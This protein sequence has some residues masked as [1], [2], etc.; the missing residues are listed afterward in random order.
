MKRKMAAIIGVFQ[1]RADRYVLGGYTEQKSIETLLDEA[2]K[3][4]GLEGIEL[5]ARYMDF[6]NPWE[7][8]NG[9][10]DRGLEIPLL[11]PDTFAS[12]EYGRGS[13]IAPERNTRQ[14]AIDHIRQSMDLA[15]EIGCNMVSPWFGNDGY[16]YVMQI[17]YV[18]SWALMVEGIRACAEH[19]PKVRIAIEYKIKEPRT[20]SFLN[21][22]A[23]TLL[24]IDEV[25]LPNV[26]INLDVGHALQGYE[27]MA[28]C[29]ALIDAKGKRLFH[30]H[31]NDNYRY[32]DDDMMPCSVHT[33]EW[34][35]LFFWLDRI[36]YG[37]W[38]SLDVHAFR[39]ADKIGVARESLAWVRG[40]EAAARRI[41]PSRAERIFAAQ[42]AVASTAML[43]EALLPS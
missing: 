22:M 4:E 1:G 34:M 38:L 13:L 31:V 21:S 2:A 5:G 39:E 11:I 30:I 23:K 37:D 17:D 3:V 35:E 36:G 32:W 15:A 42:D 9:I 41:D 24:L 10:R 40:L 7:I 20:H 16:D 6:K 28:E 43:R 18:R 12:S 33:L 8:V 19:N 14:A 26:G 29:A 25:G 27:S